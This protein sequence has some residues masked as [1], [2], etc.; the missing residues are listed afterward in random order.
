MYTPGVLKVCKN[1]AL[2][3]W[4]LHSTFRIAGIYTTKKIYKKHGAYELLPFM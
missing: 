1:T 3:F 4:L 2:K